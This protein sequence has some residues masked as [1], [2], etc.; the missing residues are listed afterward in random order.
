MF[1]I[2]ISTLLVGTTEPSGT[3]LMRTGRRPPCRSTDMLPTRA[4]E[5]AAGRRKVPREQTLGRVDLVGVTTAPARYFLQKILQAEEDRL[6]EVAAARFE[7]RIDVLRARRILLVV[8]DLVAIGQQHDIV[9]IAHSASFC[10]TEYRRDP[11]ER[12]GVRPIIDGVAC[13]SARTDPVTARRFT[14]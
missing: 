5:D 6:G 8:R 13:H 4:I 7:V 2:V 12:R 3:A 11:V 10:S 9:Q 1:S 14:R